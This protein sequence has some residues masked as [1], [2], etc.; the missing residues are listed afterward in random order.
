MYTKKCVICGEEF[1]CRDNRT[2]TCNKE[3]LKKY[4]RQLYAQDTQD[5]ICK[6]CGKEYKATLRQ[7][8]EYCPQCVKNVKPHNLKKFKQKIVCKQCGKI[9]GEREK[10][11]T[12]RKCEFSKEKVCSDCK[13][14]NIL[15]QKIRMTLNNPNPPKDQIKA[16]NNFIKSFLSNK[17]NLTLQES[18]IFI[19]LKIVDEKN[20]TEKEKQKEKFSVE[21]SERMKKNNPMFNKEIIEKAKQT[22]KKMREEGK[23]T[24]P[25]GEKRSSFV[26]SRSIQNY[27]RLRL[28][29][30]KKENFERADYTCEICGK[31]GG[32]LHVHHL[33]PFIDIYRKFVKEN[34]LDE[35]KIVYMSPEYQKLEKDIVEYHFSHDIGMV[36]CEDCHSTVDKHYHKRRIKEKGKRK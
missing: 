7:S 30:W 32:V 31:R 1:Q 29:P 22:Q 24:F 4:K 12:G 16:E 8:K 9:L 14:K 17:E 11:D 18:L 26:G 10:M 13:K 15:Q 34:N 19:L 36:V 20:R 2:L 35:N 23:L 5:C 6:N 3:C 25:R 21:S 27:I 33:E 28:Y